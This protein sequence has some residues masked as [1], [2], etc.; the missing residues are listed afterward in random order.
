MVTM[1]IVTYDGTTARLYVN[2]QLK[3]SVSQAGLTFTNA[4]DLFIG[5]TFAAA[6]PYWVNGDID[7][8]RIM[9]GR[10]LQ[11]K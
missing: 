8:V 3:N 6:F 1:W 4:D 5:K 9:T 2:C 7:E 10:L 11:M